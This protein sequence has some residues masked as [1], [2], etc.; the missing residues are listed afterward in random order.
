MVI[1]FGH[2]T[3]QCPRP[4]IAKDFVIVD[5]SG[6]HLVDIA[7]CH[8]FLGSL[9]T[10]REQLLRGR[11][12]LASFKVPQAAFTFELLETFHGLTLQSKI[13]VY[14]FYRSVEHKSDNTGM[15]PMPV[16]VKS[17]F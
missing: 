8:C 4:D 14:D 16:R 10:R 11:L 1:N 17:E 2:D 13:S 6:I 3:D 12:L 15:E 9:S 5:V 7:F